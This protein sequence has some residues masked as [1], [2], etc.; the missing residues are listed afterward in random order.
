MKPFEWGDLMFFLEF[1]R[2]GSH[3]GAAKRL[4]V[5]HTTVRRRISSLED[6]LRT[7]LFVSKESKQLSPEGE[8]LLNYAESMETLITRAVEE[9]AGRDH[10]ISGTVQIGAPEGFGA[11][12]LAPRL[13]SFCSAN[14]QLNVKLIMP[15]RAAN[16]SI[17]E[18]D[19]TIGFARP[20]QRRQI[21]R[22]LTEYT[23]SV[24][25]SPE[26]LQ[27]APPLTSLEDLSDHRLVGYVEGSDAE[28]ADH[29]LNLRDDKFFGFESTSIDA[30]KNVVRAGYGIGILPDFLVSGEDGLVKALSTDFSMK[31]EFWLIIHP[32]MINLARVR[33]VIDFIVQ[34]V[35][36]NRRLFLG[37]F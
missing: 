18:S 28:N 35:Y 20:H 32:E 19:L 1:V 21:A 12:F 15:P 5:D 4:K 16:S 26:Y 23:L 14:P 37:S 22:K 10:A 8:Q 29:A 3:A 2:T 27:D 11:R 25:A 6:G 36:D 9:V 17:R 24:Y 30:Q 31:R 7:K 13:A 33:L 34:L